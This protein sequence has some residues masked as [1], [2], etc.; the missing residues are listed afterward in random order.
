M[1][2]NKKIN[3]NQAENTQ[4]E[5][6]KSSNAHRSAAYLA[7]IAMLSALGCVLLLIE[8]PIFPRHSVA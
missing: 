8:F 7:K 4:N 2:E 5:Q 6:K 1:D 3:D